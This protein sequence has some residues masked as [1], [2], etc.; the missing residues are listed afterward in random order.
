MNQKLLRRDV[1]RSL[2]ALA[3]PAGLQSQSNQ[4]AESFQPIRALLSGNNPVT[5]VFTGDSI[6]HGALHTMGWRDYP[7]H[8]AERVRWEMHRYRDVVINTGISGDRMPGL[9]AD[10]DWRVYRFQPKVV[11]LMM[12]MNDCTAGPTGRDEYRR[13]LETFLDG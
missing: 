13:N 11:S 2:P 6:T 5:W 8:F 7:Q 4:V 3:S 1:F 9:L 12:G 10:A